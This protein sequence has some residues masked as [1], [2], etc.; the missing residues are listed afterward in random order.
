MDK[1]SLIMLM[2][3]LYP[4]K[5]HNIGVWCCVSFFCLLRLGTAKSEVSNKPTSEGYFICACDEV[6][7]HKHTNQIIKVSGSFKQVRVNQRTHFP[8]NINDF[9][10]STTPPLPPPA[11]STR[12][13]ESG[14]RNI[15]GSVYVDL[16]GPILN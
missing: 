2:C 13:T 1:H 14:K 10:L 9:P 6:F 11:G 3:K 8:P 15:S 7:Y 5:F 4:K 16:P 12:A